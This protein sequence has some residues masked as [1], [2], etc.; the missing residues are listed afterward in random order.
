MKE[1]DMKKEKDNALDRYEKAYLNKRNNIMFIF[2]FVSPFIPN[3]NMI[4]ANHG[5]TMFIL[6]KKAYQDMIEFIHD[7][8]NG[9]NIFNFPKYFEEFRMSAL[10]KNILNQ[11]KEDLGIIE[12]TSISYRYDI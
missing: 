12:A 10:Y 3:F 9:K 5:I 2:K 1:V 6:S 8:E 4:K 7:I 11:C